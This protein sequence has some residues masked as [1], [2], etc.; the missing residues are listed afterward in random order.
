[1]YKTDTI[2]ACATAAGTAAIA[3]VRVSGTL[4]PAIAAAV[5]RPASDRPLQPWKLSHGTAVDPGSGRPIDEVL[6]VVMPG[7]RS[8]TGED[9]LEI[10]CH[11]SPVVVE[12]IMG[13]V[14]AAGARPADRGEFTRR[15][16][17]NGRM[18]LSQAEA[19]IDL[20]NAPAG[21]AAEAAWEQLQGGL[22]ARLASLREQLC[23]LLA[24]AEADVDFSEDEIGEPDPEA[25]LQ[26]L[27]GLQSEV[28]SL[29]DSFTLGRRLREGCRLVL[30]GLP[31]AGKS[32]LF[33]ALLG[34]GRVLVSSEAGT[35]R[36]C[37]Q[38]TVELAGLALVMTDTAGL[39]EYLVGDTGMN[40]TDLDRA[41][42][43][44]SRQAMKEADLRVLVVDGSRPELLE[45]NIELAAGADLLLLNKLDLGC[46]L[47]SAR[48]SQAADG[49]PVLGVS[50]LSGEGCE[51]L[52]ET[53]RDKLNSVLGEPGQPAFMGRERHRVSLEKAALALQQ[54]SGLLRDRAGSELLAFE[55]RQG[56][57]GLS[58]LTEVLD[59][60][61]ILDVIFSEFCVG[62]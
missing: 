46:S 10:Q 29:L 49:A 37:V 18:D 59:N 30:Y 62:K 6:C 38:E 9:C 15:A 55:L 57:E 4:V 33:N 21:Q 8:F 56:L 40:M 51:Q 22:S 16:V 2:A 1:L 32:S 54:A 50:A 58:A 20:I 13:A 14:H 52:A 36:D 34:H 42:T 28:A 11:G 27:A 23:G 47:D 17:L 41:A 19:L 60:E 7:P 43:E 3:V 24:A 35:T 5:F 44:R 26:A 45:A 39:G 61:E 48:L 53:V 31:N 12:K 25:S